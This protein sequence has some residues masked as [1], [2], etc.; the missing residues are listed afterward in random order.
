MNRFYFVLFII[1]SY[2][3]FSQESGDI[4]KLFPDNELFGE[5]ALK[6]SVE[7]FSGEDL[8]HYI[9]GGADVFLEYGFK[10]VAHCNYIDSTAAKIRLEVFEMEKSESAYG[11]FT[12][13]SSGRGMAL[14]IGEEGILYDYYLHFY[15]AN[16]Y[17]RCSVTRKEPAL[18]EMMKE[19][20]AFSEGLIKGK[21]KKPALMLAIEFED[22]EAK[23]LKYVVGQIGLD[24]VYNFGHGSIAGFHDGV[25]AKWDDKIVFV[26]AYDNGK[27]RREWFASARGKMQ[28]SKK[29][30]NY[31]AI[32]DGFTVKDKNGVYFSFKPYGRFFIVLKGYY[33]TQ[34]GSLFGKIS[35]NLDRV[36]EL[37]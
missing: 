8:F 6:D 34:A 33:W 15:K 11:I 25:I 1:I 19:F 12:L 7:V 32:E 26:F 9:N 14:D 20:A 23:Q 22:I 16:Y 18:L 17:I 35:G 24:N 10:Q 4:L 30:S 2:T 5:W 13:N 3:A 31:T 21:G 37:R 36:G 29:F 28:M 27:N